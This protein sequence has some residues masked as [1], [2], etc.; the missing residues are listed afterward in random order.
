MRL[1]KNIQ[2]LLIGLSALLLHAC[3]KEEFDLPGGND[4]ELAT[5]SV[6][7]VGGGAVSRAGNI[8]ELTEDYTIETL[9]I[10]AINE[11]GIVE[12]NEFVDGSSVSD[13]NDVYYSF[14]VIKAP[15]KLLYVV[16]NEPSSLTAKLD[17]V[18]V[19]SELTNINYEIAEALNNDKF[20]AGEPISTTNRLIPMCAI[21]EVVAENDARVSI[22]V[23]RVVARVDLM[24]DKDELAFASDVEFNSSTSVRVSGLYYKSS[25]FAAPYVPTPRMSDLI[26]SGSVDLSRA[27]SLNLE[28][29]DFSSAKRLLSFYVAERTY[30]IDSANPSQNRI[31]I[32]I[33]N[34]TVDGAVKS[35][36]STILLGNNVQPYLEQINRNYV[37][38]IYATY[39]GEEQSLVVNGEYFIRDW[40]VEEVDCNIE[41]VILV[42]PN[43]VV[44]DWYRLEN[45]YTATDIAFGS[46][47][48][49]DIYI[50]SSYVEASDEYGFAKCSFVAQPG[51][52]YDLLDLASYGVSN[53]DNY[54]LSVPW[55]SAAT[56]QFVSD[57]SGYFEFTYELGATPQHLDRVPIQIVSANVRKEIEIFYDN[58]YVPGDKLQ[59]NDTAGC[60]GDAPNGIVFAK[61]GAALHP[62]ITPDI[63]WSNS[64]GRYEG[65]VAMAAADADRYCKEKLG[66]KWYAPNKAQLA[67]IQ[68]H[69]LELGT[70]YRYNNSDDS[71]YWS[72]ESAGG[73]SY[74]SIDFTKGLVVPSAVSAPSA[75]LHYVRCIANL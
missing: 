12:V 64:D 49:I 31:A 44:M 21:K 68:R 51:A 18:H 73:D 6:N 33:D 10:L 5:L 55:L 36:N 47:R 26:N 52:S 53:D 40:T 4:A 45:S 39:K 3:I 71:Y 22:T 34:I 35:I 8:S 43:R 23:D 62:V 28:S 69:V 50:P 30:E 29:D 48:E 67:D 72:S 59:A 75:E 32:N 66:S 74:W 9:R 54:L 37:Y 38:R 70:S 19:R 17:T 57:K 15:K 46:N 24:V 11:S 63:F 61:R 20:I 42:A 25:L 41:G 16:A 65:D 56:I 1:F 13:L 58:G 60:W 27:V 7:I 14:E 2:L